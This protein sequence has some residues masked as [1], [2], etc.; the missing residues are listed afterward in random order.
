M[1]LE[2]RK[3]ERTSTDEVRRRDRSRFVN[4]CIR[5]RERSVVDDRCQLPD[6]RTEFL[7]LMSLRP[8]VLY[9]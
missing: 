2:D 8:R 3:D 5:A 4:I 7:A 1:E 9:N 6:N